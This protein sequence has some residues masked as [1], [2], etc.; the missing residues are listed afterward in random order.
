[1][2]KFLA[3]LLAMMLA[4]VSVAALAEG[5]TEVTS[6]YKAS[7]AFTIN[8]GFLTAKDNTKS[9]KS[10]EVTG[11][12]NVEYP[13]E[14]VQFNVTADTSNPDGGKANITIDDL[15]V[16]AA[17]GLKL[18]INF[19]AFTMPGLYHFTVTEV[20]AKTQGV[21]YNTE[22][23]KISALV[24]FDTADATQLVC[25]TTQVGITKEGEDGTKNDD[26]LE[27]KFDLANLDITKTV[28]GN[29]G[30]KEQ[31]FDITLT[32]ATEDGKTVRNDITISG[33][34]DTSSNQT[35]AGTGT[36]EWTGTKTINLKIK[37]GDTI[38]VNDIP[39]GVTYTVAESDAHSAVDANGSDG[40]KGYTIKLDN[41][42]K[43]LETAAGTEIAAI[44]NTKTLGIDTGIALDVAPYVMI[45]MIALA[46]A[47][48]L[49]VRRRKEQY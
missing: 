14:T 9:D 38:K 27:N 43:K 21:T 32:L 11:K 6:N 41:A 16:N 44:T 30:D 19:P 4:M 18:T 28:T 1:M 36:S 42:S 3:I 12:T 8:T 35:V 48:M 10:Y 25:N 5:E 47:A 37:H 26:T 7:S 34:S 29:M 22:T 39:V 33:S 15:T 17:T 13:A 40:S 45:M 49:V 24:S 31:L 2:K 20:D 23:I 46:G